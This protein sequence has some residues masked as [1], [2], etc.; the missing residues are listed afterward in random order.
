MTSRAWIAGIGIGMLITSTACADVRLP[1]LFGNGM[2]VQRETPFTVWGWADPGEIVRLRFR[3]RAI[4][5][6]ADP[7][8]RWSA[9]LGPY[10]AGGPYE[11]VIA[12]AKDTITLHDVL[13]GDVWLVSGQSNAA[14]A[15]KSQKGDS[16][17]DAERE[18]SQAN[19]PLIR[20][21][22]VP[23]EPA[24]APQTDVKADWH[25]VTPATVREF[26][27]IGYFFGRELHQRYHVPVGLIESAQGGTVI[28]GWMAGGP[29]F[30][31]MINPLIPYTLKGIAWYQGESDAGDARGAKP[32]ADESLA[33]RYRESFPALIQDWRRRWGS[34]L[35][36]V[37]V[38]LPSFG[39]NAAE[40]AEYPW[41]TVRDAQR[42][43]LSLPATGM[44]TTIDLGEERDEHPK[45]KKDFAHRLAL[46]ARKVAYGE[47]VVSSGPMYRSARI[48]GNRIRIRF[49]E[50][51][52]GLLIK[53]SAEDVRGFEIAGADGRFHWA[54]AARDG[55]DVLVSNDSIQA[56]VAV[57]YDWR[58]MP[59][60]N[61]FNE[62]GLPAAPFRTAQPF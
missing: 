54:H 39:R 42:M 4:T 31:G 43:A 53:G 23:R 51:G 62:E 38:Q 61:V 24:P 16:I 48:E 50:V 17:V 47:D 52:S 8:G 25:A 9:S 58:D 28:A 55:N 19:F 35:P 12:G 56:P 30:N 18:A 20:L 34:L 60:G 44:A 5:T 40:P 33:A 41:A 57:R 45:N 32:N 29:Q 26:S 1:S 14:Y 13:I 49:T 10:S 22:M 6:R 7:N 21:F 2:V 37:F 46:V 11:M 59:D 15:V 3:G 36:F 27:A